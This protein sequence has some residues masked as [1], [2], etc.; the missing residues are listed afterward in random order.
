MK[1]LKAAAVVA[2]SM[3]LAGAV[4]PAAAHAATEVPPASLTGAVN[5]LTKGP[6]NLSPLHADNKGSA[7]GTV[8]GAADSL[9]QQ[10]NARLIGGLPLG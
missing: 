7:L 4:A 8:K 1:S 5:Q 9:T 6:V 10:G 2:G 3:V